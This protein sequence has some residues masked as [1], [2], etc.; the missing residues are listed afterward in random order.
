V[1]INEKSGYSSPLG[2]PELREK[3][4][5]QFKALDKVPAKANNIIVTP[6]AKQAMILALMVLL[7]PGDEV[8]VI[9]PSFVSFIPQF[10]IAEPN[11]E[12]KIVN[13][14]KS[15]FSLPKEE[16]LSAVG[17]QTKVVILN[18]PSNPTGT[19]LSKTELEW[20]YT[21]AEKEDFYIIS[22]EVYNRLLFPNINLTSIGSFESQVER[23]F[24]VNGYSKSHAITGWRFGFMSFPMSFGRKLLKLQQHIN[25]NTSTPIQRGILSAFNMDMSFLVEYCQKLE[26]RANLV[27]D[28]LANSSLKMVKPDS[29]F[30]A[31]IDVSRTGMDSN[32]F[33]S[34]LI[35]ATGVATTPGVAFGKEWDDHIRLSYAVEKDTLDMGINELLKFERS[36]DK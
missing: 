31:F 9:N 4:A 26:Q 11:A 1:F 34:E 22:D 5:L 30:F 23:V 36:I 8:V 16:F 24:T 17:P 25:T 12:V 28:S 2:L 32:S 35:K 10:Y 18:S 13:L 14:N 33:C 21:L 29:G 20:I 7:Q 6:G 19:I 15:D 3:L 27:F